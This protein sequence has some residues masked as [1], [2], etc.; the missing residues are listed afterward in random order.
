VHRRGC[1]RSQ[2]WS[3]W[4]R[5]RRWR[6]RHA[7]LDAK[8]LA[9]SVSAA[10]GCERSGSIGKRRTANG[11]Y[12]AC[13]HD[14]GYF[15]EE[16]LLYRRSSSQSFTSMTT[17]KLTSDIGHFGAD[18]RRDRIHFLPRHQPLHLQPIDDGE[19]VDICIILGSIDFLVLSQP[20]Q[21]SL[22]MSLQR[23]CRLLSQRAVFQTSRQHVLARR[24]MST[25]AGVADTS[26]LPL[27]GIKVLDMTRVLAGVRRYVRAFRGLT[28]RV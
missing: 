28:D 18:V 7:G 2:R 26:T 1:R 25:A 20:L 3:D 5:R 24:C 27:A 17:L 15:C 9:E 16:C 14:G 13:K 12:N 23:S 22:K 21:I 4:C 8:R 11:L 10:S 6:F 19:F